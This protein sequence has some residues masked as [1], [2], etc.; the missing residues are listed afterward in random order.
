MIIK[1]PIYFVQIEGDMKEIASHLPYTI[2]ATYEK[3]INKTY[4]I[5]AAD[6]ENHS[7]EIHKIF[8]NLHFS[9]KWNKKITKKEQVEVKYS[10]DGI[11]FQ[12]N[13]K[14]TYL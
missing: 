6:E 10:K 7:D 2:I 1:R 5:I 13:Q 8:T 14:F 3:H 4:V 11:N 12:T 9:I